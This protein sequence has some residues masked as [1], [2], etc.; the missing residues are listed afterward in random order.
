MGGYHTVNIMKELHGTRMFFYYY[1]LFTL[2]YHANTTISPF[3]TRS[4]VFAI[5]A[6]LLCL[7]VLLTRF[8][9]KAQVP[10]DLLHFS[11]QFTYLKMYW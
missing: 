2:E 8:C 10:E 11:L 3:C 6:C 4:Q 7:K 9:D 5:W 1:N